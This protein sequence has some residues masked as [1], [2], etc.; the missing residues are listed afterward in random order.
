MVVAPLVG[1][2]GLAER[3]APERHDLGRADP[4]AVTPKHRSLKARS[5]TSPNLG[6]LAAGRPV[7]ALSPRPAE[8]DSITYRARRHRPLAARQARHRARD[9]G[10][11]LRRP[12]EQ[13]A[14]APR[15][16]RDRRRPGL[17]AMELGPVG[18]L[19]EDPATLR[20]ELDRRNLAA[21]GSYVFEDL[22]D[23]AEEKTVLAIAERACRAIAAAGG[24]V[25]VM[26]D[27]PDEARVAT[28]G[29]PTP[30]PGFDERW[31]AMLDVV[32]QVAAVARAARG[33]TRGPSPRRRLHRVRGRDGAPGRRHRPRPVLDTG[34][35]AYARMDP[36]PISALRRSPRPRPLQGH[37]SGRI[38]RVDAERL[39]SG[40]RSRRACSARSARG[41]ST[42]AACSTCSPRS[43]TTASPRSNRTVYPAAASRSTTCSRASP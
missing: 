3:L 13:P 24:A 12:P 41:W 30:R 8:S 14:L 11:R 25:L 18:Y 17:P 34:H 10:R 22:H 1:D 7:P 23:P 32:N 6:P 26:I 39:T 28:A 4:P 35:L 5:G 19:P 15:P 2:R 16:R 43:A 31:A 37:P 42:S 33:A 29:R 21:A 27:R 20:A 40:R 9:L 36:S 38:D